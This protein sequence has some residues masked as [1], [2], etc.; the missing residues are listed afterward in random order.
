MEAFDS[1]EEKKIKKKNNKIIDDDEEED[2]DE[3]YDPINRY[4]VKDNTLR[5]SFVYKRMEKRKKFPF[6][7]YV[8]LFSI[9]IFITVLIFFIIMSIKNKKNYKYYFNEIERPKISKYNYSN[10]LF[11]NGLEVMLIQLEENET[12]GGSIIF[13]TGYLDNNSKEGDLQLALSSLIN[14]N[15]YDSPILNRFLGDYSISFDDHFSTF[16]FQILNAGLFKYFED[17]KDITFL[18]QDNF[19]VNETQKNKIIKFAQKIFNKQSINYEFK[20][21]KILEYEVYGFKDLF[22]QKKR[23]E[24]FNNFNN[25]TTKNILESIL[26]PNK[27]KI[28]IASHFKPSLIRKKFLHFFKNITNTKVN[29]VNNIQSSN[30]YNF[31]QKKIISFNIENNET[32]YIKISYFINKEQ[33]ET[34]EEFF[35][36][37]CYLNYIKYILGETNEDSLYHLLTNNLNNYTIESI[38]SD[39]EIILKNKIKFSIK[40]DLAPS[41]FENLNDIIFITYE[42]MNKIIKHI[43]GMDINDDRLKELYIITHQSFIFTEDG[44]NVITLTKDIGIN[45]FNKK[46]K[47]YLLK[48]SWLP[49]HDSFNLDKMKNYCSKLIPDNSVIIIGLNKNKSNK[50]NFKINKNSKIDLDFNKILDYSQKIQFY[51][52]KYSSTNLNIDFKKNFKHNEN[53]I[54]FHKNDYISIHNKLIDIDENDKNNFKYNII[55]ITNTSLRNFYLI[56][57]TRFELPK[58]FVNLNLFHPFIRPGINNDTNCVYFES[59]LFLAYMQR[60]INFQLSDAIRAGNKIRVFYNQNHLYINIFSFSD[61]L[62]PIISKIQKIIMNKNSFIDIHNFNDINKF[63]LYMQLTHEKFLNFENIQDHTKAK[64]LFYYALN[65]KLYNIYEFPIDEF[66]NNILKNK[67]KNVFPDINVLMTN[68]IIECQIYGDYKVENASKIANLF[69]DTSNNINNFQTVLDKAGLGNENLTLDNFRNWI[70]KNKE[71]I[72]KPVQLKIQNKKN[73]RTRFIYIYW[74]EYNIFNRIKSILFE[75]ILRDLGNY[76]NNILNLKVGMLLY[77]D[78]AY[79]EL[80]FFENKNK[81]EFNETEILEIINGYY[82]SKEDNFTKLIDSIGNRFYYLIKNIINREYLR[83]KGLQTAATNFLISKI[84]EREEL[85]KL[86]KKK[87]D[88]SDLDYLELLNY[89]KD[90]YKEK[91]IYIDIY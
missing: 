33:N 68:F 63:D 25:S 52:L 27:I 19:I 36:N 37:Q 20:E 18:K 50:D 73:Y 87:K 80:Q 91:K 76:E 84:Y 58:V 60:E 28:V 22:P 34:Y 35:R 49:P 41:S 67:C 75:R 11:D 6:I 72:N 53:K 32:N 1:T 14:S 56:R 69:N 9:L 45:L 82:H 77:N 74:S 88:I 12:A 8:F 5:N 7:F 64:Y 79:L 66:N 85:S 29:E 78:A 65:K 61:V 2:E 90:I 15:I 38:S 30:N 4:N 13:D 51:H 10:F 71:N 57:D 46:N 24:L 62:I 89:F 21:K 42:Y 44:Q 86:E 48:Q 47:D 59:M 39:F 26:K 31:T 43:N 81:G 40:I 17:L 54:S 16:S 23:K 55:N 83:N 3:E 70:R